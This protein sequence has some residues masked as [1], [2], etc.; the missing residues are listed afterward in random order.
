MTENESSPC[1]QGQ[2][3]V[4]SDRLERQWAFGALSMRVRTVAPHRITGQQAV[5]P[6]C[7]DDVRSRRPAYKLGVPPN[8]TGACSAPLTS[9][10][11]HEA[12]LRSLAGCLG[13]ACLPQSRTPSP[14]ANEST[15]S[16]VNEAERP[17]GHGWPINAATM[18]MMR[19]HSVSWKILPLAAVI[20]ARARR[21]SPPTNASA[22]AASKEPQAASRRNQ[23]AQQ[24]RHIRKGPGSGGP[25]R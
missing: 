24:A 12:R 19:A 21:S 5:G 2:L 9:T 22:R 7:R 10:L 15:A 14:L 17:V 8:R 18:T 4:W 16:H 20:R 13:R 3:S 23:S 6:L 25:G 11:D 1:E